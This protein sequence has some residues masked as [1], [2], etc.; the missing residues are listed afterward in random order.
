MDLIEVNLKMKRIH[1][2]QLLEQTLKR[3]AAD[4]S[5]EERTKGIE[6]KAAVASISNNR[7]T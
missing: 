7:L 4:G 6:N 2:L 3:G 5:E 1:G